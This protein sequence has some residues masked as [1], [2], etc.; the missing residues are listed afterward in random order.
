M[1]IPNQPDAENQ[2][3]AKSVDPL[4]QVI[5]WIVEGESDGD[6]LASIVEAYP[7][8]DPR[9]LYEAAIDRIEKAST[10]EANVVYGW[11]LMARKEL[12]RR[13]LEVGDYTGALRATDRIESLVDKLK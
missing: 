8:Q 12:F 13:M 6:I 9:Q 4:E 10:V 5:R 1:E 2:S 3:L 7:T 11:I